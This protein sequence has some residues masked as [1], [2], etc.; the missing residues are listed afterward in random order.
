MSQAGF[1]DLTEFGPQLFFFFGISSGGL[2]LWK[3]CCL[4][5]NDQILLSSPHL[6][7]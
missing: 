4:L 1:E 5:R 7:D 2:S 6:S 3:R